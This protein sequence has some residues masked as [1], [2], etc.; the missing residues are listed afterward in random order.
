MVCAI[1]KVALA[2]LNAIVYGCDVADSP[3]LGAIGVA[4]DAIDLKT[5]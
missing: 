4:H 1:I 2:C 3:T 5:C